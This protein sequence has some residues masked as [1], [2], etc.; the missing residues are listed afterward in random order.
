MRMDEEAL[1]RLLDDDGLTARSEEAVREALA[2]RMTAEG[3]SVRGW[4][5]VR[6]VR[7]PLMWEG[8]LPAKE[9]G[10]LSGVV[11][12]ALR[13]IT[14]RCGGGPAYEPRLLGP[15]AL[16]CRVSAGV[17][18]AERAGGGGRRLP[19]HA[20]A[21]WAAAACGGRVC[22]GSLDGAIRL[23]DRGSLP[24][25][26]TLHAPP[27]GGGGRSG[28]VLA[29]AAWSG[30]F[31]RGH[32]DGSLIVWDLPAAACEQ[33][34]ECGP[35]RAHPVARGRGPGRRGPGVGRGDVGRAARS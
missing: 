4:E 27:R 2:A 28:A 12:E 21:V 30:Q 8:Y 6:R 19:G 5:L 26:R 16:V 35:D 31:V 17:N 18:W 9:G 24:H 15:R 13:A 7:F 33:A 25:E 20:G 34:L 32:D 14:A 23:W 11:A 1:G 3:G 29:L 10:L 22:T